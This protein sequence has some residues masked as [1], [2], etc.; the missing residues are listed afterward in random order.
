MLN[1]RTR[2]RPSD[3]VLPERSVGWRP[4]VCPL[5]PSK[6]DGNMAKHAQ[7]HLRDAHLKWKPPCRAT[8]RCPNLTQHRPISFLYIAPHAA[9]RPLSKSTGLSPPIIETGNDSRNSRVHT[10]R[11]G[12]RHVARPHNF[13]ECENGERRPNT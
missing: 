8:L 3:N 5:A 10:G 4:K 12:R 11:C 2:R 13:T 6:W 1:G 7:T 9:R